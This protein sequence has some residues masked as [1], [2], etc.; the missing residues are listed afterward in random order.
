MSNLDA[1]ID[2]LEKLFREWMLNQLAAQQDQGLQREPPAMRQ[3]ALEQPAPPVPI[4]PAMGAVVSLQDFKSTVQDLTL[5]QRLQ[6]VDAA[7]RLLQEV[8]VHLP[9]KRTMHGID[10]IQRLRLLKRRLTREV[11]GVA[12][13][14]SAASFHA[15]MID[16]FHSLRDLH[17]NYVLPAS[18]QGKTAFLPFLVQEFFEGSPK[19]RGYLVTQVMPNSCP[20]NFKRG[21]RLLTWNG[22]PIERAVELN[23]AR[24]AGSNEDARLARGLEALTLRPLALSA[25]PDESW[26]IVG[27][28]EENN[29]SQTFEHRF[30]WKV[31]SNPASTMSVEADTQGYLDQI[32]DSAFK[33]G[34]DGVAVAMSRAKKAIFFPQLIATETHMAAKMVQATGAAAPNP[35]ANMFAAAARETFGGKRYYDQV[36]PKRCLD[37]ASATQAIAATAAATQGAAVAAEDSQQVSVMPEVF[38]FRKVTTTSGTFGYIRIFT[39]MVEDANAFVAEFI[40]IASLLPST[41]LILDVRGNGGGNILA[42]EQLLQVLTSERIE[43]ERFHFINTQATLDLCKAD[44]SLKQWVPSID[45]AVVSSEIFS[46]GF[47]LTDEA[48][49]NAVGRKYQGKVVLLTDALCYSTTDIFAAGFQDHGIGKILGTAERTGAGGANV[50]PYGF[51]RQ[52]L[53]YPGLPE[54][55]TFRSA[56]RRSTRVRGQSGVPLEDFGVVAD[57]VH[58]LTKNDILNGNVDLLNKAGELLV[59]P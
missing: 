41:G 17:T 25:P 44:G 13:Q 21:V 47:R 26:V 38:I 22:M 24:E 37:M 32:G 15:E 23:A 58:D 27:Y 30:E 40:R 51:F 45:A 52:L 20:T 7:T 43:P 11:A 16:I 33:L 2:A 59:G 50:W 29:P 18:Y 48:A 57:K 34:F 54:G 36:R 55:V 46:Q 49:A 1:R 35:A 39:F 8:F 4:A 10:P 14:R 53:N 56:I 6:V 19:R 31:G 5:N 12:P 42:G 9:L 28:Q 3:P